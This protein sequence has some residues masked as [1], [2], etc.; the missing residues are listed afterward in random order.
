M[1]P[2]EVAEAKKAA[3]I[4]RS[5]NIRCRVVVCKHYSSYL[6]VYDD[7]SEYP[8]KVKKMKELAKE[9]L[10]E[11]KGNDTIKHEKDAINSE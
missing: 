2:W 6:R 8:E 1:I 3:K 4:F 7:A 9:L 5:F 10:N 11:I